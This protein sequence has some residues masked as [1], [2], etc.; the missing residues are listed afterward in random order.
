[1]QQKSDLIDFFSRQWEEK[2][3]D[4]LGKVSEIE[5][6]EISAPEKWWRIKQLLAEM[7]R[8]ERRK[9]PRPQKTDVEPVLENQKLRERRKLDLHSQ[10]WI[11]KCAQ[12]SAK[13]AK[14][15]NKSIPE[16]EKLWRVKQMIK[17]L[18]LVDKKRG[19]IN[20]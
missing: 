5:K 19:K 9:K 8:P 3:R 4:A 17:E 2:C 6:K 20:R 11:E 16:K 18:A 1:M 7:T 14:M 15:E 13:C 10:E 12:V